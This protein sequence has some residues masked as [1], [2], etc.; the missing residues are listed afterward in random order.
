[1][2]R[3]APILFTF[4]L[5]QLFAK[6]H[7]VPWF[8][9]SFGSGCRVPVADTVPLNFLSK[10][11]PMVQLI[12]YIKSHILPS[13]Q[14]QLLI[15]TGMK[16]QQDDCAN[17]A[18][19]LSYYAFFSLFPLL[20]IVLSIV[21][22]LIGPNTDAFGHITEAMKQF[23]PIEVHD[24][25]QGTVIALNQSSTGAG[26]IG[27]GL[28]LYSAST[29]FG[30]LSASIDKIWQT[31]SAA[32]KQ[33]PLHRTVLS[34]MLNRLIAFLLVLGTAGLMLT[35][36]ISNILIKAVLR[37]VATFEDNVAFVRINELLLA[38][39]LQLGSSL[40]I[41]AL[42]ACILFKILPSTRV[43]WG[44]IWPGALLT[45]LLLVG[46]QQLVSNS[47]ITVGSNYLSYGV[48]GSVM[49]LLLWIYLTCQIFFIGCEFSYVYAHLFGSRQRMLG[50]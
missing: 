4:G 36:M 11:S 7:S 8:A 33:V 19:A 17:M 14:A 20:L 31:T 26:I 34:Y 32:S 5:F 21:G 46:L 29:V 24:M 41:L 45:A 30:V 18:A 35:S 49:I 28:L 3:I 15:R 1:M 25:V 6:L 47:I 22:S 9:A 37:L 23:L 39:S 43:A 10:I 48:I 38:N 42:I 13:R 2:D 27:F 44:D 16:W 40:F 12:Q 50:E